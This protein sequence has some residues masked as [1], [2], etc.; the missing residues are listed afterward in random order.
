MLALVVALP[1]QIG[2][3]SLFGVVTLFFGVVFALCVKKAGQADDKRES[4]RRSSF[5]AMSVIFGLM[6]MTS[7]IGT[8]VALVAVFEHS[9]KQ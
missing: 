1:A 4:G 7:F 2:W 6:M 5:V 3:L 9:L 8:F